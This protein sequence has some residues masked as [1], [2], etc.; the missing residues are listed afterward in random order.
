MVQLV[1][2]DRKPVPETTTVVPG[3][4]PSGGDPYPFGGVPVVGLATFA[5]GFTVYAPNAAVASPWSPT[6]IT[7]YATPPGTVP[8][9]TN[10]ACKAAPSHNKPVLS[11]RQKEGSV[12]ET[13]EPEIVQGPASSVENGTVTAP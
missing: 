2:V 4:D 12:V 11:I 5:A 1:S 9:T 7:L 3:S 8:E 10:L 13:S 6:T